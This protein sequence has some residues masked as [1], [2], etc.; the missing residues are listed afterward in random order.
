LD[1]IACVSYPPIF[2]HFV[3]FPKLGF[4]QKSRK[5]EKSGTFIFCVVA[6]TLGSFKTK[7]LR[8]VE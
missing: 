3:G 5:A 8:V 6:I 7:L 2:S 4:Q 1:T